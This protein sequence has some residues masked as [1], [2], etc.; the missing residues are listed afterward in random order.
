MERTS[1]TTDKSNEDEIDDEDED[2]DDHGEERGK[3]GKEDDEMDY[4]LPCFGIVFVGGYM[5]SRGK[6]NKSEAEGDEEAH[7]CTQ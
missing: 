1:S 3:A 2:E 4:L 7:Q 6:K 5:M